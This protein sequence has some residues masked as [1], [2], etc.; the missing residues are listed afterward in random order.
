MIRIGTFAR[1]AQVSI[2]TL[3]HYDD[4]SLLTPI[5]LDPETGYRYYS[6][7]QLPRL[8]RII[9]LKD[10]GFSL[11]Q[12]RDLL[13]DGVSLEQLKGMLT[14]K[15]AEVERRLKAEVER[16]A[17]IEARF[18]QIEQENA[19][20]QHEVV[21]KTIPHLLVASRR[22]T[23]PTNDEVPQYLN[24]A[25]EEVFRFIGAQGIK[26]SSSHLALWYTSAETLAD[27]DA[28]AVVPIDRQLESTERVKVY[29]LPQ[30]EVASAVHH[31]DFGEFN[32][33]HT[34]LLTWIEANGYRVCGP[35]REI[36][37]E[38]N[39]DDWS[40]STTEVQYPIEKA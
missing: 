11:E 30:V 34:E 16:L 37:I 9:A 28:E 14:L 3:R 19:M 1:I 36:Y 25:F 29:E 13:D 23:I 18:R 20:P 10:L 33:L 32:Q 22:I 15:R 2:V 17:R 24:P 6:V 21:K 4:L 39:P 7:S 27:E 31:G 38:H 40:Q 26:P 8:N 5:S 12:I 35:F